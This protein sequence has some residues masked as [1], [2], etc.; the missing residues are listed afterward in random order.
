MVPSA[1]GPALE[2]LARVRDGEGEPPAHLT[3]AVSSFPELERLQ[4]AA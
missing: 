4:P 2:W 3:L 1:A